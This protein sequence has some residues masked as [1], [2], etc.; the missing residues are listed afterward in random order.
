MVIS[1]IKANVVR[2]KGMECE[3]VGG[4]DSGQW[5]HRPTQLVRGSDV[6]WQPLKLNNFLL[7]GRARESVR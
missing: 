3:P 5:V 4:G 1:E 2:K 7:F 6:E